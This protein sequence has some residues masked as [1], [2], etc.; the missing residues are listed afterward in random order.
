LEQFLI[1]FVGRTIFPL[2]PITGLKWTK[3]ETN[4]KCSVHASRRLRL[5]M[6]TGRVTQHSAFSVLVQRRY[7]EMFSSAYK[8]IFGVTMVIGLLHS[9][10]YRKEWMHTPFCF[11]C[12]SA[13]STKINMI[14]CN[15]LKQ[16][17]FK[18]YLKIHH[19]R[20]VLIWQ[21]C[22]LTWDKYVCGVVCQLIPWKT[23]NKF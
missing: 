19:G 14:W 10:S 12:V 1:T 16:R 4:A 2:P 17:I 11:I 13:W 6:E 5:P 3:P 8:L 7:Y 20:Q 22:V 21:N 9:K 18:Y 23:W 15:I